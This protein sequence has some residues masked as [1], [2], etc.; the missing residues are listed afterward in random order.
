MRRFDRETGE[1]VILMRMNPIRR[2]LTAIAA[3]AGVTLLWCWFFYMRGA[4]D[5]GRGFVVFGMLMAASGTLGTIVITLTQDGFTVTPGRLRCGRVW[6][7]SGNWRG[8]TADA[9]ELVLQ[10][11]ELDNIT[12]LHLYANHRG[13][14]RDEIFADDESGR[15]AKPFA[16]WLSAVAEIPVT[17]EKR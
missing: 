6:V 5:D 10:E 8:R 16:T 14:G 9:A 12:S 15:I 4:T 17:V 13:G 7:A 2:W 11:H 3:A 1:P